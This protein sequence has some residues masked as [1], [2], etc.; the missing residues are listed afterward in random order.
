MKKAQALNFINS[1][2][3]VEK[4][5]NRNT[6][7][8]NI[9]IS[10]SKA[11]WWMNIKLD[12]FKKDWNILLVGEDQ[13]FWLQIPAMTFKNPEKYFRIWEEKNAV[14]L[15]VSC[16][17][18]DRYFQDISSGAIGV[19]FKPF[20]REK[21][22]I[23]EELNSL[24]E[25][26]LKKSKQKPEV[27]SFTSVPSLRPEVRK[28]R[29]IVQ[30]QTNISYDRLFAKHLRGADNIE[31]QDPWIRLPYQFQNL[32]EFCV[33]LGNNKEPGG[34]INLKVIS[35][36]TREFQEQSKACFEEI[37][38][39]VK[40]MRINL[41]FALEKHHDRYIKAD[42]G[43]KVILGRGLDIY[44]KR[45]GRFSIGDVDQRWRKCKPCEITYLRE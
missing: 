37:A 10:G 19:D 26:S 40:E 8:A 9:S 43:C 3:G 34:T 44:E 41:T 11:A 38:A 25:H 16:D 36:N 18:Q 13:L 24:P 23:P 29:I 27:I 35:W 28:Q 6:T 32:L 5:K 1:R 31:L 4:L 2:S 33:M 39:S 20:I 12:N 17:R 42:N 7:F 14:N 21:F 22:S 45:E 30:D 15:V